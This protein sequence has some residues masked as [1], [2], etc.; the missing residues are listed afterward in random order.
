MQRVPEVVVREPRRARRPW[1]VLL[2]GSACLLAL[3]LAAV[4]AAAQSSFPPAP[5]SGEIVVKK[6]T[7]LGGPGTPLASVNVAPVIVKGWARARALLVQDLV[8][9]LGRPGRWRG[10]TASAIDVRLAGRGE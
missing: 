3:G 2:A 8:K 10:Q 5:F 6:T 4:P 7:R 1:R 9:E